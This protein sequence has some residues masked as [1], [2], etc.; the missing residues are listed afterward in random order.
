MGSHRSGDGAGGRRAGAGG[1]AE[2]VVLLDRTPPTPA[3]APTLDP[4]QQAV[5]DHR[6]GHLL[7]LAG[8]G[9][10]KTTTLV[11][12]VVG[13]LQPGP[14]HLAP[15]SVLALTFGRRAARELSDRIARRLAGGP[16]PVV[17]TFHSFAYGVLRQY[18]DPSAFLA[19]PRLLTAAEQ[20]ARLR[21]LLTWSIREGRLSWPESLAGA[22][23]T[24]GIAE[25]VRALLARARGQGL[26]GAALARYG[27]RHDVP[28]WTSVGRF[29]DEYLDTLGFE[30][31]LDYAELIH[32]AVALASKEREGRALRE[33]YKLIVVD[34]Y[35]DTDPAQVRLLH[36]LARG[37]A[38]V[39]AVGDPDQAIYGFRGADVG[40]I[41][42]FSERFRDPA[43][44]RPAP[45][46]VLRTTRRF[47][48]PIADAAHRVL[49]PVPLPGL[50]AEVRRLHRSPITADGP[51]RV[52]ART[53]PS[54]SAEA[55]GVAEVLLRAHAGMDG[56]DPIPW[57]Q[58]AVL[59]RNP[60][61]HGPVLVRAMRSAG[62]PVAVPPDEVALA[63]EP[64]VQVLLAVVGLALDPGA[65]PDDTGRLLLGGP[66]GRVD[67][68]AIRSL[69]RAA[70]LSHRGA[71]EE[72]RVTADEVRVTADEVRVTADEL[73]T[74]ALAAGELPAPAPPAPP[75]PAGVRAGFA[76]VAS[77]VAAVRESADGDALVSEALWAGWRATDWPDRLRES[78]LRSQVGATGADRDLDALV[79]LFDLANRLP[80]QRRGRVGLAAFVE[81]VR[82]LRLPQES[83]AQ[84]EVE[85]DHV[86]VLSAHRAK[87]LEWDLV[88]VASV[89]E[90]QWP[91]VRLRSDLLHVNE[92]DQ[93]GRVDRP[94]HAD[95]LAEERRLMYVACTR[96]RRALVV[97]A[98]AEPFEGGAQ[99]SR[100]LSDLGVPIR[101]MSA[102]ASVPMA[103]PGLITALR[104]AATAE[105]VLGPDGRPDPGVEAL[106]GA[107]IE[108]LAALAA[109][110]AQ[111]PLGGMA[112]P[113]AAA[114]PDRWWGVRPVSASG[115]GPD[116]ASASAPGAGPDA[117]PAA[118]P[119]AGPESPN[120]RLSPSSVEALRTC[121]L[122][123]FLERRV[124]AGTPAGTHAT[125]GTVV[126]AVAEA[127]ARGEVAPERDAIAP[128][129]DEIWSAM[130]FAA[131]Y[132][133]AVERQRV[134]EMIDALLLWQRAG[135]RV[136]VA[137]EAMFT[138]T[139]P[140]HDA[141]IDVVG[142]V[143]RIDR[144]PDG[145]IHLVD[146]KTGK[147]A[148]SKA[149]AAENPQLG[150]YQL[151]VREGAVDGLAAPGAG[152]T[153]APAPAPR[154]APAHARARRARRRPRARLPRRGRARQPGRPPHLGDADGALPGP[155]R[156]RLD[157]GPRRRARRRPAG[158]GAEVPGAAQRSLRDL[159]LP[160]HVP[161]PG[162][163]R[164][165]RC[166]VTGSIPP[167]VPGPP[168]P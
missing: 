106:R 124:G 137:A 38:Q 116:A 6:D 20:D 35:Q 30:G 142:K 44:G 54:A 26:D 39:V 103:G 151:A 23:G 60:A 77:A 127:L 125:V 111:Q 33:T 130:P 97:S 52:E 112:G 70:L 145:R 28:V 14:G 51:A 154:P 41:L 119:G 83:R 149:A 157:V 108:R 53:Y 69:A 48:A 1:A 74:R 63:D 95:L 62:V 5:V 96:P 140:S 59:V 99:H 25:Q 81:E 56:G 92:L 104:T 120:V 11:E 144:A 12:L 36:E 42:E 146:F 7:V 102:R 136:P 131:R 82:S 72:V 50:A 133:S 147:S 91:D 19:P 156:R 40:G 167:A 73:L 64:S 57:S 123:W 107:A 2:P 10:G 105:R 88:V 4:Q 132:H 115:A 8:P 165:G 34:E 135:D 93:T 110:A 46:E 94:S 65:M 161:G 16:V 29:F 21:E 55:S 3:G 150:I 84:A 43:S 17:S 114:I 22:V 87:G 76:R 101:A 80:T 138:L 66:L 27:R 68:V 67:P 155:D 90:G 18:S 128:L 47:P 109:V 134:D 143:D 118:D 168:A 122:R 49:G 15:E 78:A 159:R 31:M 75:V 100:F 37:G 13:R 163:V 148:Q 85:R 139:L 24:R 129:V 86:R 9:T 89:Q 61:V 45:I 113:L 121:P 98:V 162:D 152:S 71:A 126:H 58:M 158:A 79:S 153:P 160:L 32:Q 164:P 166:P 117:A 141:T